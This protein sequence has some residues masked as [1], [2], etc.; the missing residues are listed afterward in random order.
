M[1][2]SPET[3]LFFALLYNVSEK[4]NYCLLPPIT[5]ILVAPIIQ[6]PCNPSPCGPNSHCRNIGGSAVCACVPGYIGTPPTCRPECITSSECSLTKACINQKCMDPCIGTCGI[7]ARCEVINHNP[8]CSCPVQHT[9]DPFTRCLQIG[10]I[11]QT[12]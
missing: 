10:T 2:T 7:R 9:G 6:N 1:L 5:F 12:I 11:P 8:I 3:H 4:K